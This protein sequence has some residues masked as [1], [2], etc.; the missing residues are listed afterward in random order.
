MNRLT[1]VRFIQA[2]QRN[3]C[4]ECGSVLLIAFMLNLCPFFKK[5]S[6]AI[7]DNNVEFMDSLEL[8]AA[9]SLNG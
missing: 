1:V 7:W 6:V 8:M 3:G 5:L 4:A 9:K 2:L